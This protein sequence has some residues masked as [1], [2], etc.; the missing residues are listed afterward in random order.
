[1]RRRNAFTRAELLVV[2]AIIT[3]LVSMLLPALSRARE[4]ANRIACASNLRQT[5]IS[6]VMY[7][8]DNKGWLPYPPP[9]RGIWSL[10]GLR[11]GMH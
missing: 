11:V 1:M 6:P 4:A 7:T 2:I 10:S 8:Q 9:M 5:Y 3:V